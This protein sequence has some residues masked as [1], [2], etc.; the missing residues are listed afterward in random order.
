[1]TKRVTKRRRKVPYL[2]RKE[3]DFLRLLD[4]SSG[5]FS[6]EKAVK[7]YADAVPL[8]GNITTGPK[9]TPLGVMTDEQRAAY[10]RNWIEETL[11]R[12]DSMQ[13]LP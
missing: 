7:M 6:H 5:A 12:D 2:P 10:V 3:R 11:G 9:R 8:R 4:A 1:M 13:E